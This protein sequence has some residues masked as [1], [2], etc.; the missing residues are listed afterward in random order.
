MRRV[1][2]SGMA[3]AVVA[4][5]ALG[6]ASLISA[7]RSPGEALGG[8]AG[9]ALGLQLLAGLGAC[10]T[11]VYFAWQ[12][13]RRLAGALLL[14]T[15]VAVFLEQLPL[16]GT[17]G[18]VLF[19][20]A[21]AGGAMTSALAG[22]AALVVAG[23]ARRLADAF[24][25]A[26]AL[27]TTAVVLGLGPAVLFDP[28]L[29]GCFA[30]SRNLLLIHGD[31]SLHDALI[32]VGL[33]AAAAACGGLALL[34]LIRALG[35]PGLM[36]STSG[37]VVLG[38]V[39]A[40]ALGAAL[41]AYEAGAGSPEID[42]A[43]R[44][45]WLLECGMFVAAAAGVALFSLRAR[46]LRDRIASIVVAAR[47][48]AETL[49]ATLAATLGDPRLEIVFP[50]ARGAAVNADGRAAAP[51]RDDAAVAEVVRRGE[52]VAQVRYAV[53]SSRTPERVK[54]A[55][56]GAGLALEHAS[57]HARLE[58]ELAE[59][60]ASRVRIV[61]VGDAERR[62][63]ERNLHD[64]AQ[65]RLIALSMALSMA[66][67]PDAEVHRAKHELQDALDNLRAIAHGIYPVSLTEA[68]LADAAR[69]LADESRVPVRIETTPQRRL[70]SS[71]DAALYRLVLDCVR[72]AER[73]GDGAPLVVQIET[74]ADSACV[75]IVTPGVGQLSAEPALEHASDRLAALSGTLAIRTRGNDLIVEASVPCGL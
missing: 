40:A 24:V 48:S 62:R 46:L 33:P 12:G 34:A 10:G 8:R 66:P 16:P 6:A 41:F 23:S 25:A 72:L 45:L 49:R 32:R 9:W 60:A 52:V 67:A 22:S 27:V 71:V 59:L 2:L 36:R 73:A 43:T 61:E 42:Q 63:L 57:L 68:G 65:Q 75:R 13:S 64:G 17:D 35:R 18:P 20:V 5:V 44:A 54:Q 11:G 7:Y 47:P 29:S 26:A 69:E 39:G 38:G 14:A 15:G 3:L 21:L 1:R 70:P 19:T 51:A 55:A 4:V 58:A 37:P 50:R 53:G 56:I 31:V 30:C 28:R 74:A